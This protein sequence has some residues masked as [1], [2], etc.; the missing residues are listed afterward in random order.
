MLAVPSPTTDPH[1][2][3]F[4]LRHEF[5]ATPERYWTM[6]LDAGF[7]REMLTQGLGFPMPEV[8]DPR[9]SGDKLLRNMKVTPKVDL[10]GP[11]ARVLGSKLGYVEHGEY[12]P[13][14][15]TW[16][17]RLEFNVMPDKLKTSGVVRTHM[18]GSKLIR[19]AE[20]EVEAKV[21]GI[22]GLIEGTMDKSLHEGWE[23]GAAFIRSYLARTA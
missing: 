13:A 18:E 7:Q 1:V 2:K 12:E 21:F 16:R 9:P 22:G 3:T 17:W 4:T 10:P 23:K 5:D 11:V 19:V 8:E 20:M 15:H 6:F 14:T